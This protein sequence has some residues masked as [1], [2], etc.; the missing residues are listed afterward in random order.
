MKETSRKIVK[1][2]S[3]GFVFSFLPPFVFTILA[4][5]RKAGIFSSLFFATRTLTIMTILIVL[6]G[7]GGGLLYNWAE[8]NNNYLLKKILK[9][10]IIIYLGYN[11]FLFL[12]TLF[13]LS[14]GDIL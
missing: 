1:Y 2:I 12:G 13:F 11:L 6:L 9:L 14:Q 5:F 4:L 10:I 7:I 3:M 8:N